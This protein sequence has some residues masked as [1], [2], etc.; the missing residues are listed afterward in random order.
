MGLLDYLL[1]DV[2]ISLFLAI[3]VGLYQ[4]KQGLSYGKTFFQAWIGFIGLGAII[5]KFIIS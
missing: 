1:I 3:I 4:Y 2:G 5:I